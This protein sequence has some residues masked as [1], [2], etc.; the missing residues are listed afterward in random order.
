MNT[1]D[2]FMSRVIIAKDGCW[3]WTGAFR[4]KENYGAFYL[5]GKTLA[6]H[7]FSFEFFKNETIQP[8]M[9]VL[10]SCDNRKCVNPNH[11]EQGTQKKN[12][13]DC[14]KRG[15]HIPPIGEKNGMSKLTWE[16]VEEI[17]KI[18]TGKRGELTRLAIM[19]NVG[20]PCMHTI[21]KNKHWKENKNER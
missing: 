15:R 11:L 10:H 18:Y 3:I 4:G 1:K 13:S 14:V 17:R 16:D 2:K 8:R 12:L 5:D 19:Y 20:V 7:R 9:N 21:V 6:A